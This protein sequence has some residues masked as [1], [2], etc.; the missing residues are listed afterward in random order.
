LLNVTDPAPDNEGE[1]HVTRP[2]VFVPSR[3]RPKD[4][5]SGGVVESAE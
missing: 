1:V 3:Y 4:P 5:N 2:V